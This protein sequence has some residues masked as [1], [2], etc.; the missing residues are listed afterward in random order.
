M[1]DS[2]ES[3]AGDPK[4]R[5]IA[6]ELRRQIRGGLL[7]PGARLPTRRELG[8]QFAAGPMTIQRAL[9]RLIRDGFVVPRGRAGTFVSEQPPHLSHFAL[10]IHTSQPGSSLY[11]SAMLQAAAEVQHTRGCRISTFF[12]ID[13]HSDVEDFQR[14]VGE[15]R[16][17]RL[18][19]G[20]FSTPPQNLED[21]PILQEP[22]LPRVGIMGGVVAG[23]PFVR[24]QLEAWVPQALEMLVARGRRRIALIVPATYMDATGPKQVEATFA[25]EMR[26]HGLEYRPEW[27]QFAYASTAWMAE[28]IV[29]LL[30]RAPADQR[31]DGL[32]VNDDHFVEHATRGLLNVGVQ[33]S[34]D[35][36]VIAHCNWPLPPPALAPVDFLG[37]DMRVVLD[38]CIE[39][40]EAQRSGTPLPAPL[41]PACTKAELP[42]PAL[43]RWP[44]EIE[45]HSPAAHD[46]T[47]AGQLNSWR[48]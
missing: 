29:E 42:K 19:G 47:V 36:D 15:V 46:I 37:F 32:L 24:P 6:E 44:A 3:F 1:S 5:F 12:G 26:R 40:L 21:T 13:G 48:R 10:V 41:I 33:V 25:A 45:R 7:P 43:L 4:H 34:R 9:D 28:R 11:L 2:K 8:Q 14:L 39:H 22:D 27:V 30:M 23:V 31:P 16:G 18:A 17:T 35:I 38:R 20:I